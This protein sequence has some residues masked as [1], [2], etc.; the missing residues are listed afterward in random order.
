MYKLRTRNLPNPR[1]RMTRIVPGPVSVE[2]PGHV[3][4]FHQEVLLEWVVNANRPSGSSSMSWAFPLNVKSPNEVR[5]VGVQERHGARQCAIL[6][7]Q[8]HTDA[9]RW[10][11]LGRE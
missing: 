3:T 5:T 4:F 7:L 8:P 9:W 1:L 10:A 6:T 11:T 2:R